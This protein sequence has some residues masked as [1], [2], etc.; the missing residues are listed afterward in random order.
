[1]DK[2]KVA[3]R[4]EEL[5]AGSLPARID[6]DELNHLRHERKVALKALKPEL[7]VVVGRCGPG[8]N[9]RSPMRH[10]SFWSIRP[11]LCGGA[12]SMTAALNVAPHHGVAERAYLSSRNR[13]SDCPVFS[14]TLVSTISKP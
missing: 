6:N 7:A 12:E 4:I 1:M 14:C 11:R 3:Q 10:P 5:R 8:K 2:R 9:T 13:N